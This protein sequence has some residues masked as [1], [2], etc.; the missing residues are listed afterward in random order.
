MGVYGR[1]RATAPWPLAIGT[2][3]HSL[4]G[5]GVITNK[6]LPCCLVFGPY[7]GKLVVKNVDGDESGYG[8]QVRKDDNRPLSVDAVDE[9][10][11]NWMRYVNC[12]TNEQQSNIS[13]F[14]YKGQ[15]Y[16]K[17]SRQIKR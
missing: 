7:Q 11:S 3:K 5:L 10:I 2:S 8:W 6:D 15:I 14:Q 1:A 16:Y 4:A 13:S 12:P 17:T 9:T